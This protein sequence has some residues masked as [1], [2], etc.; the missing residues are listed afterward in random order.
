MN[1][2]TKKISVAC[3]ATAC[4]AAL[5]LVCVCGFKHTSPSGLTVSASTE[6]TEDRLKVFIGDVDRAA[7]GYI[8]QQSEYVQQVASVNSDAILEAVIG[9]DDYYTVDEIAAWADKYDIAINRAYMWPKGE[10]GRLSLYVEDNDIKTSI[11]T[12]K[13]E[14]EDNSFCDDEQFAKDYQRFLNGEYKVFAL[15]VTAPAEVLEAL[16]TE[17]DCVN[18][19]D[20]MYN[21]EAETYA[22]KAGKAVSY[23]EL[24]AKPDGA[25]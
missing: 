13:Q 15:T 25:L 1:S 11:E 23:I 2:M 10:T 16:S 7:E 19:V 9:L 3:A 6:E 24:P 4:V 18:Y 14:V 12:Y 8:Q 5:T 17:A 21:A 20:V 22:E